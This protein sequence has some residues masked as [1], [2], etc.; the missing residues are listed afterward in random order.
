MDKILLCV[1]APSGILFLSIPHLR[2]PVTA[3][4]YGVRVL[5]CLLKLIW[6]IYTSNISQIIHLRS[7][8]LQIKER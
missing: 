5:V 1:A 7:N 3:E 2:E 8:L 6:H 4:A